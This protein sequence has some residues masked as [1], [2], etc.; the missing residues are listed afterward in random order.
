MTELLDEVLSIFILGV[1][2]LVAE[3]LGNDSLF[4]FRSAA[5][6]IERQVSTFQHAVG[7]VVQ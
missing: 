3:T 2:V 1:L 5:Q 4:G 7:L 6:G